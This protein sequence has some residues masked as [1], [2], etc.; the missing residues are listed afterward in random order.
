MVQVGEVFIVIGCIEGVAD[1]L[2]RVVIRQVLGAPGGHFGRHRSGWLGFQAHR[3]PLL[4][5]K[6]GH[7]YCSTWRMF[8]SSRKRSQ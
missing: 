6:N 4:H 5:L 3:T 7:T 8:G 1:E 2:I